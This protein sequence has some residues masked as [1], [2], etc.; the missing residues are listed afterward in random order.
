MRAVIIKW[1]ASLLGAATVTTVSAIYAPIPEIEKGKA[2][3]V[4][5]NG[6]V[7]YDSNI[8]GAAANEID[9]MI[10]RMAP[11]VKFNASVTDRTFLS[12]GYDLSF[13]HVE[14]RPANKNLVSHSLYVR[15]AHAV[16]P[17]TTWD[18]REAFSVV[19]N[20]ESLLAGVPLNTDQSYT[21]NQIDARLNH[22]LNERLG[23]TLKSRHSVFD[24]RTAALAAGLD[25]HELLLGGSLAATLRPG[26]Q[27]VGEYRFQSIRYDQAGATKDKDSHFFLAGLD[28]AIDQKV[29]VGLRAGFEAR[30][31]AGAPNDTSPFAEL[32]ARY[33][34]G[35]LSFVSG[36][37]LY[38]LEESSNPA[39]Y[40]DVQVNR[41]FANL[42]HAITPRIVGAGA[43][44]VEPSTLQGRR[45][46][47][48]DR[49]ETTI[50][51]GVAL[52]YLAPRD[53]SLS[54]T[55]DIDSIDSDDP[56]RDQSRRRA[57][58]NA[59]YVF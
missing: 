24:Y 41:W 22:S 42:Q 10:W 27:A 21:S 58:L 43:L 20:P 19:R 6:G 5:L 46:V 3:V 29:S 36:G 34:Y 28:Y 48:S 30:D 32:T 55:Y 1:A 40:T 44:T 53:W 26:R 12:A 59:R 18:L 37:F 15:V 16:S 52:T 4:T 25:R 54:L 56:A 13:D 14:D 8:F 39:L 23:L 57:G 7:A 45:G 31:R 49:D 17:R 50:R 11:S 35:A 51:F 9:S 38:A 33:N 2:W 47:S